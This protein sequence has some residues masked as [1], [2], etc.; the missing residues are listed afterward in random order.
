MGPLWHELRYAVRA[1][2]KS[3]GFAA[4]ALILG[5]TALLACYIP[6]VRAMR[7][8]PIVALRHE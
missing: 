4:V 8:D 7:V 3:P 6:A 1:L 5:L 2:Q